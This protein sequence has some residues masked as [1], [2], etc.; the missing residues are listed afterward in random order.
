[1]SRRRKRNVEKQRRD[2]QVMGAWKSWK[3]N[4]LVDDRH[5]LAR[6]H[7][8]CP[9]CRVGVGEKCKQVSSK[10]VG[11]PMRMHVHEDRIADAFVIAVRMA[12]ANDND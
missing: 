8:P 1:M 9:T 2:Y 6:E 11:A 12:A 5:A 7:N 4:N 3:A 10:P